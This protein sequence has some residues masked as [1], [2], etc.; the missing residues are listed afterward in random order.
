MKH[1]PRIVQLAEEG[2]RGFEAQDIRRPLGFAEIEFDG[3][4]PAL[5]EQSRRCAGSPG[6]HVAA[7]VGD[8]IR[9]SGALSSLDEVLA[10]WDAYQELVTLSEE[11]RQALANYRARRFTLRLRG[12]EMVLGDTP[13]LMGIL[14]VTPDSFYDGG[15]YG[16]PGRAVDHA[17]EMVAEGA[18]IIDVGGFSTRPG[19][20]DVSSDEERARVVPVIE[21]LAKQCDV[22]VS[23]DTFR[24]DVAEAALDVGARIVND[25]FGLSREPRLADIAAGAGAALIVMHIQGVPRTMQQNP[26]YENVMAE[27]CAFLRR[28]AARALGAGI[29]SAQ[30]IVDPGIGFGKALGHNVEILGNLEQLHS[31]GHPV[32]VGASR[33]SF[34]GAITGCEVEDRLWGTLA[35]T[36]LAARAGVQILRVHDVGEVRASTRVAACI[37]GAEVGCRVATG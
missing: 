27:I 12:K 29:E 15:R 21:K 4:S 17:L 37:A 19:A 32:L 8:R 28:S 2:A 23:V 3:V 9:L 11:A 16:D 1:N 31:L 26:T 30:V 5:L 20:D 18:D 33:K 36:A 7:L 22:A 14:N 24:A 10:K 35:T 34:V 6:A 13:L 25:I